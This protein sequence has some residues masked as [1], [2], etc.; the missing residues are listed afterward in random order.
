M[1]FEAAFYSSWSSSFVDLNWKKQH[2]TDMC[3]RKGS[4]TVTQA[5]PLDSRILLSL[6]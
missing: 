6:S 1:A 3:S 5:F 2:H 4:G